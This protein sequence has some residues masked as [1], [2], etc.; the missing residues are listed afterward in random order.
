MDC[1]DLGEGFFLIR[2]SAKEDYGRALKDG[3]WFVR[4]HYLSMWNWEANFNPAKANVAM[5]A[6]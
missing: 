4:G 6:T 5:I 3:P 2:F 1:V